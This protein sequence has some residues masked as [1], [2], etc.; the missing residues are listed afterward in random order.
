M[1]SKRMKT[2]GSRCIR[3]MSNLEGFPMQSDSGRVVEHTYM[4][5]NSYRA[6]WKMHLASLRQDALVVYQP[7]KQ[8][9]LVCLLRHLT[10]LRKPKLIVV[11]IVLKPARSR[12]E[13]YACRLKSLLFKQVDLFLQHVKDTR[14]ISKHYGVPEDRIAYT[15]WKVNSIEDIEKMQPTEGDHIFTGGRSW[16]DYKTFC[17]AMALVDYPAVILTPDEE[18]NLCHGTELAEIDVP[19]NVKFVRDN[20]TSDSWVKHMAGSRMVVLPICRETVSAAGVGAYLVAMALNKPVIITECPATKDIITDGDQAAIVPPSDP[21]A[22]SR[23]M[24]RVWTDEAY[25]RKLQ[26]RGREYAL[27]LG[28]T[29]TFERN[30]AEQTIQFVGNGSKKQAASTSRRTRRKSEPSTIRR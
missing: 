25:R 17:E 3:I 19:Q 2:G 12:Q 27:S 8:I 18:E 24:E 15:P 7:N 21:V 29:E 6:A 11:D 1:F 30:V 9:C 28:G 14:P 5:L 23:A 20:G 16:R 10:P 26:R 4:S 13:E 22:L